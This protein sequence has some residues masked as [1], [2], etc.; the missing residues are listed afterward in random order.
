MTHYIATGCGNLMLDWDFTDRI[1][2]PEKRAQCAGNPGYKSQE[3]ARLLREADMVWI[4]S[5]WTP[6]EAGLI[7]ESVANVRRATQGKVFVVGSKHFG[8]INIRSLLAVPPEDRP[9][10]RNP[11]PQKHLEMNARMKAALD[12]DTFVDV[13]ALMCGAAVDCALFNDRIEILTHDGRHFTEAGAKLAGQKLALDPRFGP[14]QT[15]ANS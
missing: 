12:A 3:L 13:Q 1:P 4:A 15:P 11:V 9:A 6:W 10:L 8:Q 5:S 2:S 7:A 14:L